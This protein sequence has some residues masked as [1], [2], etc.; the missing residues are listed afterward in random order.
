MK[1]EKQYIKTQEMQLLG[2]KF[3]VTNV[4]IKNKEIS[5]TNL[6]LHL[7]EPEKE[8]QTKLK[9]SRRKKIVP[10]KAEINETQNW[11]ITKD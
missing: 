4:Y 11:K 1:S 9:V 8:E 10:I 5:Q 2:G 6:I 3:T 7:K